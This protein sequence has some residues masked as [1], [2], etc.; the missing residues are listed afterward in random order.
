MPP[1]QTVWLDQSEL[2]TVDETQRCGR[3]VFEVHHLTAERVCIAVTGDVDAT[4]R[5]ALG[6]FVARHTRASQQMILDL[7]RVDFFGSQGFTAL[8]YVSV[9]CARREVDWMIVGNRAVNRILC[10][11]DCDA[12]LPV[13]DDLGAAMHRHRLDRCAKHHHTAS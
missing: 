7:S 13:V 1:A 3:A 2:P 5:Q 4:N 11:C 12:E 9:H 8:F 10:I 6:R